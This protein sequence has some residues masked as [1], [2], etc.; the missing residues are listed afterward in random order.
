M[1][2]MILG[3][4]QSWA[5]GLT[6]N[7]ASPKQIPGTDFVAAQNGWGGSGGAA[8]PRD[9]C[10]SAV[11]RVFG[12]VF[13]ARFWAVFSAVSPGGVHETCF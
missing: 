10:V 3:G 13:W 2:G 1:G 7:I 12:R 11:G 8:S 9:L 4:V 6:E 5:V